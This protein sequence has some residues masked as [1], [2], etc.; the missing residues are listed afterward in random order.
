MN[1]ELPKRSYA[2]SLTDDE[3]LLLDAIALHYGIASRQMDCEDYSVCMNTRYTHRLE[4]KDLSKTLQSM[5]IR[6]YIAALEVD[7]EDADT[8]WGIAKL[9]FRWGIREI[10]L[11]LWEVER[12][13]LWDRYITHWWQPRW[14]DSDE[15][16]D[17]ESGLKAPF[18]CIN[19][20]TLSIVQ[21]YLDT[22]IV[23]KCDFNTPI[24]SEE[25]IHILRTNYSDYKLGDRI[26]PEI[27]SLFV[28][29]FDLSDDYTCMDNIFYEERRSWWHTLDD[30]Q[31]LR[32]N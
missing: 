12:G 8:R 9:G 1:A 21:A 4:N 29:T 23:S 16:I 24:R 18:L 15:E 26:F 13:A 11:R 28:P 17:E 25:R 22:I 30:L 14:N 6:Q 5:Q 2:T 31:S 20:P 3:L 32:E 27:H 10:G 7:Y 19:S